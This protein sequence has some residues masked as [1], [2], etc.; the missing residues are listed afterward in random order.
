MKQSFSLTIFMITILLTNIIISN[1]S[2]T[3]ANLKATTSTNTSTGVK[4]RS[5][6][7]DISLAEMKV[8]WGKLF[9]KG[10]DGTCTEQF[11][12]PD[13][14]DKTDPFADDSNAD[15]KQSG[16]GFKRP[17][18]A[19]LRKFGHGPV[20][21]LF[22]YLDPVF[23]KDFM[24]ET[25]MI[26]KAV[27]SF[28]KD[29]TEAYYDK[30]NLQ[31]IAPKGNKLETDADFKAINEKFSK[32]IWTASFNSCQLN[33]AIPTWGWS[34]ASDAADP[35]YDAIVKYDINGDGRLSPMEFIL[36]DIWNNKNREGLF[37][38][39]CYHLISKKIGAIFDY[40][41]CQGKGYLT[42]EELWKKLPSIKRKENRWNIYLGGDKSIRCNSVNDLVLKNSFTIDGALTKNEFITAVLLGFWHRVVN[43]KGLIEDE[44]KSLKDLRW[45]NNGQVDN[46]L[47]E[48]KAA[49]KIK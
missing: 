16:W 10:R 49:N 11:Q 39:A 35:A 9:S 38:Y 15:A 7:Q 32:D 44:S 8:M 47:E 22:D 43:D 2:K 24:K 46:K 3:G 14:K 41:D 31:F 13:L 33:Q 26:L 30:F 25:T 20:A 37:C 17:S 6:A 40:V 21:Y 1:S 23:K 19:W 28:K 5:R 18:F 45:S 12:T 4:L 48:F 42:A 34:V 27:N 29:D 36:A